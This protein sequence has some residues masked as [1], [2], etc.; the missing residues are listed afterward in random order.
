MATVGVLA[1]ASIRLRF[2]PNDFHQPFVVLLVVGDRARTRALVL[3]AGRALALALARGL[4]LRVPR[5]H[6]RRLRLR[7]GPRDGLARR[8]GR[9]GRALLRD[10]AAFRLKRGLHLGADLPLEAGA[11]LV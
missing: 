3:L 11:A 10:R 9:K 7:A 6:P 1:L 8:E 5:Q 2:L 4:R